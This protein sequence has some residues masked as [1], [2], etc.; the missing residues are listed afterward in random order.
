MTRKR[1][2]KLLMSHGETPHSARTIAFLYHSKNMS[3]KNAYSDYLLKTSIKRSFKRISKAVV[4]CGRDLAIVATAL[5]KLAFSMKE[6][7]LNYD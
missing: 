4:E 5:N 2:I 6:M 1:F 3:Y 7:P